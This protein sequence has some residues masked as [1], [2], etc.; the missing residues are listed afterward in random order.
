VHRGLSAEGGPHEFGL[1]TFV[2]RRFVDGS[3]TTGDDRHVGLALVH[4]GLLEYEVVGLHDGVGTELA[5]TLV[6]ATGY[7]SRSEPV[8]RPN[9]AGP[10]DRLEGPQLQT[11]LALDYAVVLHRGDAY[12]AGLAGVADDVL[13]PLERVRGGG[14]PGASAPASGRRLEVQGAEVSALLRDGTGALVVRVVNRTP[15]DATVT[16]R[17]HSGVTSAPAVGH[18]IDLTGAELAPFEGQRM[19]RPWEML[20]FRL[21]DL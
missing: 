11:A 4:D 19:L 14:W 9:P 5:L 15:S 1:P 20:T 10:L 21:A 13:V 16:V 3:G 12:D 2:S 6:R 7:L 17:S 18:A 8:L